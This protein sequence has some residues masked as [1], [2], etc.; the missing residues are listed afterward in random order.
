MDQER[1]EEELQEEQEQPRYTPRP[2]WQVWLARIGLVLFILVIL[3]Y[4]TMGHMLRLPVP[5]WYHGKENVL[6]AALLQFMLTLPPVILNRIYY[7]RGLKALWHRA[8]NMDSLIAIGSGASLLYGVIAIVILV[9]SG[10]HASNHSAMHDLYFE[11]A[12]MI[13]TLVS[14]GKMLGILDRRT[15]PISIQ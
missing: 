3:M 11:S 12:A 15:A 9:S 5:D 1:M 2:R 8:P 10:N 4:F 14:F 13:L 6:V 7:S